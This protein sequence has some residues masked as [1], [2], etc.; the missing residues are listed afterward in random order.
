MVASKYRADHVGSLLRPPALLEARHTYAEGRLGYE[1]LRTFEDRAIL[2][3]LQLQQEIGLDVVTDGEYRRTSFMSILAEAVEG[4]VPARVAL[5]WRGPK[6]E[7]PGGF[8][9]SIGGK[10]RQKRRLAAH[11]AAF[12]KEH[13]GGPFKIALPNPAGFVPNIDLHGVVG[14]VYSTR[15]DLLRDLANIIASEM[16]ALAIE[17]VPYIQLDA[18]RYTQFVDPIILERMRR[19]GI[20]PDTFLDEMIAADNYC[21]SVAKHEGVTVGVHL[22]RGNSRSRWLA[23]GSY[24]PIAEKLFS[25]LNADRF[26]LE[27]DTERA[28]GFEPLRFMPRGKTVV[29]GLITTKHGQLEPQ[30]ALLRRIEEASKYVPT[31]D[32]ALSP[33]CGFASS[34]AGNLLSWDEQRRKLELVV[35][36]A[37]KVWG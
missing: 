31:D 17:G 4:F 10:L 32:L 13:A 30:D 34:M 15:A 24:E 8:T 37:R 33:Q 12:L 6:D 23:E 25:Q 19:S 14:R 21:L 29:L 16:R 36:T 20:N 9:Q 5:E 7:S 35:D 1:E 28:G 22:C 11:E 18:P 2:T 3:V 26:L 27:Y